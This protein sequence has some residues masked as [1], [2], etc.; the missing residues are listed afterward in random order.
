[1]KEKELR[2]KK[3]ILTDRRKT[4]ILLILIGIGLPLILSFFQDEGDFRFR[5]ASYIVE[6]N[7]TPADIASIKKAMAEK[8]QS[9]D[10]LQRVAEEVKSAARKQ[11]G[12][13]YF[14][15]KWIV[16]Q[17]S[18]FSIPFK[19]TIALGLLFCLVGLGKLI[20]G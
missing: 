16:R 6:R 4:G 14:K 13:D 20:L 19:Y 7:L 15:D 8:K 18:G 17:Y 10:T 2:F 9:L 5:N 12:E 1:M 11:L 3:K